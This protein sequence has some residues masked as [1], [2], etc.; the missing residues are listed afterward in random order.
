MPTEVLF[1]AYQSPSKTDCFE[2]RKSEPEDDDPEALKI[3][4]K[5]LMI[6][7]Y[8]TGGSG[9]DAAGEEAHY[10]TVTLTEATISETAPDTGSDA[11][12]F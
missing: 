10:Y 11:F 4:M 2:F 5:S 6:T 8:S 12:L 1:G 7:S 9:A 3:D